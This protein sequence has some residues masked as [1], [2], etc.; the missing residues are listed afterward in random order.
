MSNVAPSDAEEGAYGT[1]VDF[2]VGA[3]DT[4]EEAGGGVPMLGQAMSGMQSA[5]HLGSAVYDGVTGDRDGAV[6]H[7]AQALYNAASVFPGFNAVTETADQ[8][9]GLV[10]SGAR[11]GAELFGA[12]SISGEIPT[13]LD[14]IAAS[15]AVGLTNL[16]LGADEDKGTGTREGEIAAGVGAMGTMA[17]IGAG[18]LGWIPGYLGG[19]TIGRQI[20]SVTSQ[21]DPTSGAKPGAIAQT[22]ADLHDYIFGGD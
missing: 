10:G 21:G 14:D 4:L 18:P 11:V 13:G 22:G 7:G 19:D 17:M 6:A 16:L 5:Y 2:L 8:A 3:V 9:V 1:A 12:E 15:S 20:A